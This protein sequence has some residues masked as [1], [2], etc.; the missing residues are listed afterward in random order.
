MFEGLNALI[1]GGSKA[2]TAEPKAPEAKAEPIAEPAVVFLPAE[3]AVE[4]APAP[5]VD[6]DRRPV[7]EAEEID[8]HPPARTPGRIAFLLETY[9]AGRKDRTEARIKNDQMRIYF[10]RSN[11]PR[12]GGL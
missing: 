3:P 9:E 12:F 5:V 2:K 6:D 11:Q 4:H 10:S 7:V 1:H 8:E